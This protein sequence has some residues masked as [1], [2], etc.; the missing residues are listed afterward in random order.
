MKKF[1]IFILTLLIS[2]IS[3]YHAKANDDETIKALLFPQ[4]EKGYVVLKKGYTKLPAQLNY[5][6]ID[7]R[8][9]YLESDSSV[10]VL[11]ASAVISV[12]IGGHSFVPVNDKV[13]Y[14]RIEAGSNEL[15]VCHKTKLLS[16]GKS[17]GYGSYSQTAAIG[18]LAISTT[19]GSMY[20]LGP[21]EKIDGVDESSVYI[22]SGKKYE[23]INSLKSLLKF[24]K[25]HQTEI[26]AY[27][28]ENKTNFSKI[29]NVVSIVKYAFSL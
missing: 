27:S 7:E 20:L 12:V 4:F 8:M 29:E 5:D 23:R 2:V 19:G 26:E 24:F 22:H 28:K 25:S 3:T 13:F 14:E 6:L 18:G 17:A 9:L 11:D 15:Y 21:E 10:N 1:L 16:R